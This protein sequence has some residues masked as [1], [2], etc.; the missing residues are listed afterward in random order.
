MRTYNLGL[1]FLAPPGA[2]AEPAVSH[3]CV[4]HAHT[5]A[6]RGANHKPVLTPGCL[7]PGELDAQVDRLKEELET[8]RELGHQE[9]AAF[10]KKR[11]ER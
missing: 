2:S 9:Y 7:G 8:V 6:Y 1:L 4:K 10:R 5:P 11:N 3:V